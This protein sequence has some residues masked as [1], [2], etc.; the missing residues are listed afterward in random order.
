MRL[1]LD[2]ARKFRQK[3]SSHKNSIDYESKVLK[4]ESGGI[5]AKFFH[6][7]AI[8]FLL[9]LWIVSS[10]AYLLLFRSLLND[11]DANEFD[12]AEES[13]QIYPMEPT[14]SSNHGPVNLTRSLVNIWSCD[15][16]ENEIRD[17]TTSYS[18]GR[19][20]KAGMNKHTSYCLMMME[21]FQRCFGFVHNADNSSH[22]LPNPFVTSNDRASFDQNALKYQSAHIYFVHVMKSSG[23]SIEGVLRKRARISRG[24]LQQVLNYYC[25]HMLYFYKEAKNHP[26]NR[27]I[28][29]DKRSYGLHKMIPNPGYYITILRNPVDRFVSMY[30][31][32]KQHRYPILL[33][34]QL[35][36]D[37]FKSKDLNDF[38]ENTK[39]K[40]LP[41]FDNHS[42]RMFQFDRYPEVFSTFSGGPDTYIPGVTEIV[43]INQSHYEEALRNLRNCA[44]VGITERFDESQ[45]MLEK[46]LGM[47]SSRTLAINVN[48]NYDKK[49]ITDEQRKL[50]EPRIVYD[51]K[52]YKEAK[53]IFRSQYDNYLKFFRE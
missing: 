7:S 50:I 12:K 13:N 51:S 38:L 39:N 26:D 18:F 21:S 9:F 19:G 6:K 40:Q 34:D 22:L 30:Y 42:I 47:E 36:D 16:L 41:F 46:M 29:L 52:F 44:F 15:D 5:M 28:S 53:L 48:Q 3:P 33:D 4:Q 10:F 11:K 23:T 32:I 27:Y 49:G 45:R 24:K 14:W 20:R 17:L 2:N 35:F 37:V 1:Q 25:S 43:K 31:Y 8:K